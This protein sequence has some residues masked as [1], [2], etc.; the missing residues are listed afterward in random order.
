MQA[1]KQLSPVENPRTGSNGERRRNSTPPIK[2]PACNKTLGRAS[3]RSKLPKENRACDTSIPL[4]VFVSKHK[5]L[6]TGSLHSEKT[7]HNKL[8]DGQERRE[9]RTHL[10][11]RSRS[12][13]G[14]HSTSHNTHSCQPPRDQVCSHSRS[15]R[16]SD[17]QSRPPVESRGSSD[18]MGHH[19]SQSP[20]THCVSDKSRRTRSHRSGDIRR[21]RMVADQRP[22][23][24]DELQESPSRGTRQ[25]RTAP[26]DHVLRAHSCQSTKKR[27]A[28]LTIH[29]Q[30]HASRSLDDVKEIRES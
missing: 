24:N 16:H 21:P 3:T 30:Q 2:H 23:N 10:S 7:H 19:S 27:R 17:C 11:T 13:S 5:R 15:R 8:H 26:L 6:Q 22:T 9:G 12:S 18:N 25:S 4:E 1:V 28:T 20:S 29:R 14:T